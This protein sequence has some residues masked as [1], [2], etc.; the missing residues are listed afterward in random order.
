MNLIHG[1]DSPEN[2][3]REINLFFSENEIFEY[4]R[5]DEVWVHGR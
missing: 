5:C 1:A 4:Q 2:A 3:E